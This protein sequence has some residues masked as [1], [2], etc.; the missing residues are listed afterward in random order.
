[1]RLDWNKTLPEGYKA[2]LDLQQVVDNSKIEHKLLELLKIRASQINGCAFCLD[3][4]TKDAAAIGENEQRL[5]LLA[6]WR[7]TLLFSPRERAALAWCE[8]LTNISVSHAPDLIYNELV[9]SFSE[10]EI[11][12]LTLAIVAINS[13]NRL[14]IGF[15]SDVGKYISRRKLDEMKTSN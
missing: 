1:M 11:V 15:R 14:A 8:T 7:D 5:N 13:W 4:H 3:M 12:E 9:K 6:A 2:M 10:K